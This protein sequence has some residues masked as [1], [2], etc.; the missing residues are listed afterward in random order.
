ML[1]PKGACGALREAKLKTFIT[2]TS[3]EKSWLDN[4]EDVFG[5]G[6]TS[7]CF[8]FLQ[9]ICAEWVETHAILLVLYVL[10]EL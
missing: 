5:W 10:C 3:R 6:A 2:P 7:N 8:Y 1:S 9:A 4:E